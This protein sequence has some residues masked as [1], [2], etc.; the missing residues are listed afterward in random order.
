MGERSNKGL[1]LERI[2][3]DKGYSP[4]NCVWASRKVQN[5]NKRNNRPITIKGVTKNL[6]EWSKI[7]SISHS[8]IIHRINA[9]WDIELAVLKP[10]ASCA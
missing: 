9:G 4:S 8:A 3:N 5:N 1:S 10:T 7:Y 6:N 2:D